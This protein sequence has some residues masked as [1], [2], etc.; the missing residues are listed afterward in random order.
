MS[1]ITRS[2]GIE[3]TVYTTR[4]ECI[5]CEIIPALGEY[6]A[7]HDLDAIADEVIEFHDA[8]DEE[9]GAYWLPAQGFYI[10]ADDADFWASVERH[11][12]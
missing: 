4:A 8:Y 5:E 3:A 11:A 6:A 7:D 12:L 9:A 2:N 1:T 10:A